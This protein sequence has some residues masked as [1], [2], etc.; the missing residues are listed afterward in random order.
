ME[1]TYYVKINIEE[2]GTAYSGGGI[3]Q[4]LAGHMWYEIYQ[5][6][7]LV[8]FIFLNNEFYQANLKEVA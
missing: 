6:V 3:P 2:A 4:S 8:K 1:T 5:K 7:S